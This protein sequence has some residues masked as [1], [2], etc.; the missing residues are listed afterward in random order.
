MDKKVCISGQ[1]S[2]FEIWS[3]KAWQDS[4]EKLILLSQKELIPDIVS[5]LSL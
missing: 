2:G 5:E 3:D 1:G 4:E